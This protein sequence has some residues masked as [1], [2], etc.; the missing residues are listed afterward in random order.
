MRYSE[1]GKALRLTSSLY[2]GSPVIVS[3]A[4]LLGK[5]DFK[6]QVLSAIP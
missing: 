2:P 6:Q 4:V 3:I 1:K 5:Y